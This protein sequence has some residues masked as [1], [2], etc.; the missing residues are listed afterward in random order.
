MCLHTS[1]VLC[2]LTSIFNILYIL[3]ARHSIKSIAY[4]CVLLQLSLYGKY[5]LVTQ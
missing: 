3:L 5:N 1:H 4:A 2:I